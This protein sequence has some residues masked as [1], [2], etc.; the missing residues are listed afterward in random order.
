MKK[1]EKCGSEYS[2]I[3]DYCQ[4]C[5]GSLSR[6][7]HKKPLPK[8]AILI[9]LLVFAVSI[10]IGYEIIENKRIAGIKDNLKEAQIAREIDEYIAQPKTSDLEIVKGYTYRKDGNYVYI[11]GS[12]KNISEKTISYYEV[13]VTFFDSSGSVVDSDYTNDGQDLKS[14][15]TR[16][17]EIMHKH[18]S[19]FDKYKLSIKN[20][21]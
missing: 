5:G 17:F 14:G 2:D 1:C 4:N 3:N 12:V 6:I 21:S 13:E 16:K 11:N 18:D 9:S 19:I 15:E 20:V 8:L 7:S 10:T